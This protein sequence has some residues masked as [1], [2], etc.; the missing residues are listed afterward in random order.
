MLLRI[1]R[2][3]SIN[4][5]RTGHPQRPSIIFLHPVGLDSTWWGNQIEEFR[6][7]F[8][9]I[10][11]DMPGHGL[12]QDL[13]EAPTFELLA[14]AVENVMETFGLSAA[15]IVG[16]SVG[17]MIAQHLAIR[18]PGLILSLT[19]AGTL[20]TFPDAVRLALRA[21]AETAREQG[22]GRIAEL[23]NERWFPV[24]FRER[25]PDVVDR[26]TSCLIRRDAEFQA[27]IWE[28]ISELSIE[29]E[30]AAIKAPTLIIAGELDINAPPTAAAQIASAI[31][32]SSVEIMPRVGHMSPF[33]EPVTFNRLV[34]SFI[35][36]LN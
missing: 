36:M 15:H 10:A 33:E 26:S 23:S 1:S 35:T 24:F 27:Q 18:S 17:G 30:I 6:T 32:N 34:R 9:V 13:G 31:T 2:H 7:D 19:L 20:C 3:C 22:M 16:L 12:S 14:A 8:D 28:M 29:R 4:V 25:R 21:R 5:I 11:M